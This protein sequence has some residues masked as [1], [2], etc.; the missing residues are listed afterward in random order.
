[1]VVPPPDLE[2][3]K[4]LARN[5]EV[6]VRR[7]LAARSDLPPELLYFLAQDKDAGVRTAAAANPSLPH[8][9][10]RLLSQD[11]A[12]EVRAAVAGKLAG[13]WHT[14]ARQHHRH[15]LFQLSRDDVLRV[16][17]AIAETLK[18]RTDAPYELIGALARDTAAL[19]A[20]PVLEFSPMLSDQD[21]IA[22]IADGAGDDRLSAIA[23]RRDLAMAVSD[24]LVETGSV[25]A[26]TNLLR[27][28]RAQIREAT[29]DRII[30]R[31]SGV[32]SWQE[33]LVDRDGLTRQATLRLAGVLADHLIGRL[34]DRHKA[35]D[36]LSRNLHQAVSTRLER[37]M[38]APS[39][40]RGDDMM[41]L[42]VR[43]A[44]LR[45]QQDAGQLDE[46]A[47]LAA[48]LSQDR[49][50]VIAALALLA[51]LPLPVVLSII[52]S[53]SAKPV[54][55]LAWKAGLL[56]ATAVEL[57]RRI[58]RVAE[59]EIIR[60]GIDGGYPL[61]ATTMDWQIELFHSEQAS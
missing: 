9:A 60:P 14:D 31:S 57:Q 10:D 51:K 53:Q 20:Q 1:M 56:A 48:M 40:N 3:A 24:A 16:R 27:N 34:L 12:S 13:G 33:A 8:K 45:V 25:A 5:G 23:R 58:A 59:V 7:A 6:D 18:A 26:I 28:S 44:E 21:L 4:A 36:Q 50:F 47:V 2:Q 39:G 30:D 29:I 11:E 49:S 43:L 38:L 15:M 41:A 55:A 42:Q 37:F 32:S 61:S 35:D 19:V 22:I 52:H 17:H 54:C 46:T